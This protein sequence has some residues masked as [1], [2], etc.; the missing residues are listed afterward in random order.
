M[1]QKSLALRLAAYVACAAVGLAL[2]ASATLIFLDYRALDARLTTA[3]PQ[4]LAA[5][6]WAGAQAA[7]Q[8]DP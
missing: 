5:L 8:V 2:V 1:L 7:Y 6:R 4:Q 3:L